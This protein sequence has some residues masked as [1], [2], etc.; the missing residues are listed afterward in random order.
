MKMILTPAKSPNEYMACLD[1]WQRSYVEALRHAVIIS[2]PDLQEALKWGHLVYFMNGPV[3][4]IRAEPSRVLFGFWKG[5]RLRHIEPRLKPGGKYE[6]ATLELREDTPLEQAT[7]VR[8][9]R[10]AS[11]FNRPAGY[12]GVERPTSQSAD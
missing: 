8:L 5:Q 12:A 10:E 6:M 2:A 4:L 3:L 1:G 9:V 7:V 11:N